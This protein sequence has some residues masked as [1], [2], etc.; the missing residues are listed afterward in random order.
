LYY[1]AGCGNTFLWWHAL[2]TPIHTFGAGR[3]PSTYIAG[4]KVNK[5]RSE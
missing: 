4:D 1:G 2:S 3:L 5:A